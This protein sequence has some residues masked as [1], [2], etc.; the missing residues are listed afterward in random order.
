M[1]DL[2]LANRNRPPVHS[3]SSDQE[4]GLLKIRVRERANGNGNQIR[5]PFGLPAKMPGPSM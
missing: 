5:A 1:F 3:S 2:L 4:A